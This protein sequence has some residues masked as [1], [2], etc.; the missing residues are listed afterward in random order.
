MNLPHLGTLL[1]ARTIIT[2]IAFT[3]SLMILS[4]TRKIYRTPWA[5]GFI[6]LRLFLSIG[7]RGLTSLGV[8][9][10]P[11]VSQAVITAAATLDLLTLIAMWLGYGT[12]FDET[13]LRKW[14]R[15]HWPFK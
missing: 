12:V 11:H 2:A 4:D 6:A 10:D 13:P 15:D 8:P 7:L 5:F 3:F 9:L 14:L 1:E